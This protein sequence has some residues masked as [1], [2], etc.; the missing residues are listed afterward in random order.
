MAKQYPRFSTLALLGCISGAA[1]AY[2]FVLR[3]WHLHWGATAKEAAQTLPGDEFIPEARLN[4][5]HA[6]TIH[7]PAERIWPWLVQIGQGRGGFYSYDWLENLLGLNIH[8]AQNILP[9]HQDLKVGDLIPLAAV[10]GG[11]SFGIPVAILEPNQRLVLRGDTRLDQAVKGMAVTGGYLATSWGW[12]LQP[13]DLRH[14]RLV[15][16]FRC[17]WNPS[18][19]NQLLMRVVMEPGSFVMEHKML[20]GIKERAEQRAAGYIELN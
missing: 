16:R 1:A 12:Y 2:A 20:L 13:L 18:L 11:Q 14:T 17:D 9:K 3:P 8:S 10:K 5:T 6:I 7:A 4:A 19:M 15:E